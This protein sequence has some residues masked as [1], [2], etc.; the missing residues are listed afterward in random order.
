LQSAA[1][2]L[3]EVVG[4]LAHD[5]EAHDLARRMNQESLYF[6]RLADD[7][8]MPTIELLSFSRSRIQACTPRPKDDQGKLSRLRALS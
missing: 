8:A 1:G 2:E 6:T 3:A 5:A 4:W 7:R